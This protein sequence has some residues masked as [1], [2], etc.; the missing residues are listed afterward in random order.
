MKSKTHKQAKPAKLARTYRVH[1][2]VTDETICNF[3]ESLDCPRSL[4]C[5]LLYRHGE[6]RQLV[7]LECNPEDH[8]DAWSF[9]D[10]YQATL[11]LAKSNFLKLDANREEVALKKFF[12]FEELCGNTN[13][14]FRNLSF[15]PSFN[16]SNVWLLSAVTR[17][18]DR[19]L[20]D[21]SAEEFVES[22]N[23]GPGVTLDLNG[24][25]VS[26]V[27]KFQDEPGIT[28]E[29]Y[30]FVSPWFSTAYPVWYQHI[31]DR[32]S[33]TELASALTFHRGN[34]V[35]TVPKNAKTD[36]VIAV[37]P[38]I[39][40]WFQKSIGSMIRRRLRRVGIDLNS[41]APNQRLAHRSSISNRLATVDFSSA[42]D[43]I[44]RELVREITPPKWFDVMD[45]FRSKCGIVDGLP[46][47]WKKFSSMG[48]GFTFELESLIFYAAAVAC[49][50]YAGLPDTEV[51]VF[52]DD[53]VIPSDVYELFS[54]F[55]S[56][57]GFRVNNQKSFHSGYFRE[58]CGVHYYD[59]IDCKPVY[60]KVGL[61]NAQSVYK[62]ANGIRLLAHRRNAYYGCDASFR[63]TVRSL[64]YRVPK[65]L[66]FRTPYGFGDVGFVSNFDEATPSR[67]RRGIEGYLFRG[68]TEHG[69]TRESEQTGV[70]LAR[71][72]QV[73]PEEY[74][75][76]Y[77]LRGRTRSKVSFLLAAQ[78]YDLGPWL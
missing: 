1:S 30:S 37:E 41:Q 45:R 70:L 29:A 20:G 7:D 8:A 18:M 3:F 72:W 60:L 68:L 69:L 67:A 35:I 11:F 38:G 58:S 71:L 4:T 64:F 12:E 46:R 73:G 2:S 55:C 44:A 66:R 78:W 24:S 32:S 42:S 75:N 74:R 43:S 36:R 6:H 22:S 13:N 49:C 17:K 34:K 9:R 63:R 47:Y 28:R 16:G 27:N 10:S 26:P 54:Q 14:R 57:L 5:W 19:I 50:E 48:N 40:L 15:D 59:G 39:N 65:A 33:S 53:V 77:T 61:T 56:F 25:E 76:T 23:W 21:F 62:L 31:L 51:S 52:G